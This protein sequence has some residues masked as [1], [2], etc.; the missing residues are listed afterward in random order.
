MNQRRTGGHK[1]IITRERFRSGDQLNPGR[2]RLPFIGVRAPCEPT[3]FCRRG[4]AIQIKSR[5]LSVGGPG[6]LKRSYRFSR[7]HAEASQR[8]Y[9]GAN[10]DVGIGATSYVPARR[11]LEDRVGDV[12]RRTNAPKHS[13]E[14][15]AQPQ[16][17]LHGQ[18]V[19]P[20]QAQMLH[21]FREPDSMRVAGG[22][23]SSS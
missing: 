23:G 8:Q 6:L 17:G 7:G 5:R 11:T 20:P 14:L 22:H 3:G 9:H 16:Q 2:P 15:D 12:P 4:V 18:I 13:V 19:S 1:I 21:H 10:T